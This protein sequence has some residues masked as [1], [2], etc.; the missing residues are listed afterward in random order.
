LSP[1]AVALA[2]DRLATAAVFAAF[3]LVFGSF[4]TVVVHRLPRGESV[5]AP[6]S[7]CPTCG[8]QIR[9]RDNV[10]VLSYLALR[11]RCSGC[12]S[13]ISAEYPITEAVTAA[14]FVGAS[15]AFPDVAVAALIAVF[16]AVMLAAALIDARHR[17]IPNRLTYPALVAGAVLV[18]VLAVAGR[19]VSV[20]GAAIGFLAL[21]GGL[22]MIAIVA[23]GG[24]GMG[25]VKLAGLIGLILGSIGLRYVGVAAALAVL[26]GGVGALVALALGRSRRSAIPFGPYLAGGASAAAL[27]GAPIARWYLSLH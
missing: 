22:L 27:F 3:G 20:A 2:S 10:P 5:I 26:A 23:S 15:L 14:L 13:P 19:P 7:A 18:V 11:G 6:R 21:G 17:I 1:G 24:M 12:S 16:L 8:A 25:D 4:L 9:A